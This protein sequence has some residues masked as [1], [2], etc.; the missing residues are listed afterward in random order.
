MRVMKD[1]KKL[2][3]K[4]MSNEVPVFVITGTDICA[5]RTLETYLLL[6]KEIECNTDFINDMEMVLK[7]FKEFSQQEGKLL[8][9]KPD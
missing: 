7:E 4:N 5:I 1:Q 8:M 9:K 2:L 3:I 6:A